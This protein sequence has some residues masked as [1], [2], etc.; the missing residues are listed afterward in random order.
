MITQKSYKGG[1][2]LPMRRITKGRIATAYSC[3][4]RFVFVIK[5]L[6]LFLVILYQK[7]P[8]KEIK[9]I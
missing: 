1:C 2:E 5:D 3:N 8:G 9:I 4:K 6:F 7:L